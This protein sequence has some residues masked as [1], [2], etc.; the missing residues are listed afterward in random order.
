MLNPR[1]FKILKII[2]VYVFL[3]NSKPYLALLMFRVMHWV[4]QVAA[5]S[6]QLFCVLVLSPR[7]WGRRT[8]GYLGKFSYT[9]D[10]TQFR[11][12]HVGCGKEEIQLSLA[13]STCLSANMSFCFLPSLTS[14]RAYLHTYQWMWM[15]QTLKTASSLT[16]HIWLVPWEDL[17]CAMVR[18]C[19][20]KTICDRA[21]I[22]LQFIYVMGPN[23]VCISSY[24]SACPN[25]WAPDFETSVGFW[26]Y[27]ILS[28]QTRHGV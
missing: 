4:T 11:W 12:L 28:F 2:W 5:A 14:F 25:F 24:N 17:F 27:I 18:G 7:K 1:Q 9:G 3:F 6:A 20:R 8:W 22:V 13:G 16:T 10:W 26:E 23:K 15:N 21:I 19:C